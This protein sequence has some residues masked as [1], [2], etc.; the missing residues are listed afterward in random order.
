MVINSLPSF[1]S[2]MQDSNIKFVVLRGYFGLP[3]SISHDLDVYIPAEKLNVFFDFFDTD[4]DFTC[5]VYD[6]RL[7]LIKTVVTHQDESFEIDIVYDFLYAGL[8]YVDLD[9]FEKSIAYH[10]NYMVY[11][12]DQRNEVLISILKELLHNGRMRSDKKDYLLRNLKSCD[13]CSNEVFSID[14]LDRITF[15]LNTN[16]FECKGIKRRVLLRLVFINFKKFGVIFS[17][18]RVV[19]FLFDK[20]GSKNSFNF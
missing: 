18:N 5:Q 17:L 9:Q 11:L 19:K 3:N 10:E 8:R 15:R 13:N 6:T 2:S 12:P 20:Y 4:N 1:L 16:Y 14:D 7:G